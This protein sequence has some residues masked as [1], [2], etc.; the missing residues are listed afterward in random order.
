MANVSELQ[1]LKFLQ[2]SLN[3]KIE[4]KNK[5]RPLPD[6]KI[7]QE[8]KSRNKPYQRQFN[9]SYYEQYDWLCGCDET[10]SLFCFPCLLFGGETSWTKTGITDI[11]HLSEKLKK[12]QSSVK[13]LNNIVAFSMLGKTNIATALSG[14]YRMSI[15]KHNDEVRKNRETL[16]KIIDC[17]KLCGKLELP[18]RGHDET[19]SSQNPGVFK[20]LLEYSAN[21]DSSLKTHFENATVFKGSS[22]TIQNELLDCMLAVCQ[23]HIVSEIENA[24]F[25]SLMADDT[26][27]IAEKNQLVLVFRYEL[28]GLLCERFWGFFNPEN[29]C[30]D[31]LSKCIIEQLQIVLKY[32]P[33]KLIAQSYDGAAVM[34]G[35]NSGV[36]VRVK[37]IFPNAHYLHCYAHQLNLIMEQA[38][39]Q[40]EEARIFFCSLS[41]IPQFFSRSPQ[42]LAA[43]DEVSQRIPRP[44]GTRWNFKSRTVNT[45]FENKE[46][47]LKCFK[48]LQKREKNHSTVQA[49]TGLIKLMQDRKFLFF[50]DFFHVLMP[51]VDVLYNQ[52]Q[53]K[54]VDAVKARS[55]IAEFDKAV[56]S[57]RETLPSGIESIQDDPP[58]NRS[59]KEITVKNKLCREAKEVCDTISFQAN[60]RFKFTNHLSMAIL[61]QKDNFKVYSNTFPNEYLEKTVEAYPMLNKE[62]LR[63]ELTVLYQREDFHVVEGSLNLLKLFRE[64]GLQKSFIE[65]TKLLQIL[66]TTP[67]TTAEPER[68]F[69]TLKRIK[70]YLRNSMTEDRLNA[71]AMLSLEKQLI[72][73]IP[74]FNAKVIEK[75]SLGKNRRMNFVFK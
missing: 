22:K 42:R 48:L 63:T 71:L 68:C 4:V 8:A 24:S 35:Q 65:L 28:N 12:H 47:L 75:F 25:L 64:S 57:V 61:L 56:L 39:S 45:V 33:E 44:S 10:K 16:S 3:E 1:K 58:T 5:G 17:I 67:M 46:A 50:L 13:H 55:A 70:T 53:S 54:N 18:L 23:H 74:G 7:S 69:S 38:A 20:A 27:D 29:Q 19:A 32:S 72:S 34:S 36:Q 51:H 40:T 30:S 31:G 73:E 49:S 14:A 62:Q 60:E 26:T 6:I 41:G 11:R 37:E 2:L 66:V 21:L 15:E 59:K 9:T 43:L 52:L